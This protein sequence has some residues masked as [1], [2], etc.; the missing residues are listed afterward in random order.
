MSS[1]EASP[2]P[3]TEQPV[4]VAGG[5]GFVG[6]HTVRALVAQGRQVRVLLRPTSKTAALEGLPVDIVHG[7]VTDPDS[8]QRAMTGCASVFYS[9]VDPRFWLT[10]PTPL[11]RNNVDGLVHAM[12]AV[13]AAGV[14]RFIFTSTMGTLAVNPA[15]PVTEDMPFNWRD[16][17]TDYILARLQAEETFLRYCRDKGLPGVA[18]CVANTYGPE[19]YQPT[20][21]GKMLWD[22][23]RGKVRFAIDAGAPMVDIRDVAIAAL[24]AEKYGRPGERYIIA[25]EFISNREFYN[26]AAAEGGQKPVKVIPRSVAWGIAWVADGVLKLLRKKDYLLKPEAVFLSNV[27]QQLDKTARHAGSYTGSHGRW[28]TPC[29]TR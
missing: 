2:Q 15:G 23:A 8:L 6:S 18:L 20:P 12:D 1:T 14:E 22:V 26:M 7:D 28:R 21:H 25:N 4:L 11:Y 3:T 5:S 27:F 29:G 13:L 10:D 9:V 16:Q 24:Q 19:D 17:A